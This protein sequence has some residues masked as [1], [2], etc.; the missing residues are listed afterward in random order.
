MLTSWTWTTTQPT[1]LGETEWLTISSWTWSPCKA[2]KTSMEKLREPGS[3]TWSKILSFKTSS[4]WVVLASLLARLEKLT[5]PR[6]SS[7][8]WTKSNQTNSRTWDG[9]KIWRTD[10]SSKS[11]CSATNNQS[12]STA[13]HS[14]SDSK[15]WSIFEVVDLEELVTAESRETLCYESS[16]SE[17]R[18]T[19]Y[20]Q[21]LFKTNL[22]ILAMKIVDKRNQ[23]FNIIL[24]LKL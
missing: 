3:S 17:E 15:T 5:S 10:R 13:T 19:E 23:I 22:T 20:F 4:N 14:T 12:P 6:V 18:A 16:N 9:A 24:A 1:T 21:I 2:P 8:T 11:Q 7:K